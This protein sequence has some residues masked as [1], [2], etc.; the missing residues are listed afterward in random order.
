MYGFASSRDGNLVIKARV[1]AHACLLMHVGIVVAY[2]A[3]T[4]LQAFKVQNESRRAT[5]LPP[6]LINRTGLWGL[7]R[8]PNYVGELMWWWGLAAFAMR[9]GQPMAALGALINTLAMVRRRLWF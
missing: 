9:L 3:D 2:F 4:Q 6:V 5:G 7:S 1:F 8:H